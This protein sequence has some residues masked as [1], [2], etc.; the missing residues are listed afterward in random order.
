M[1]INPAFVL[2][3]DYTIQLWCKS[4]LSDDS[5][6]LHPACQSGGIVIDG[7]FR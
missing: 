4:H 2:N 1:R 3:L 5:M 6:L 7:Y